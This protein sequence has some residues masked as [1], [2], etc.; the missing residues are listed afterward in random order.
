[1][2]A[3]AKATE[4]QTLE[5]NAGGFA[6]LHD[7]RFPVS[8]VANTLQ[9]YLR[10]IVEKIQPLKVIL[11]GSYAYGTP[12]DHSDFDLLVIRKSLSSSKASNME[13]RVAIQDVSAP[14]ASFTFLSQTPAGLE[15]KMR[16]ESF[17]YREI[18][19]KG[20]ELYAAEE[21]Q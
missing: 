17:I 3:A 18:V 7:S 4:M 10:A 5:N 8:R 15:E 14:P 19:E 9:P 21:N 2:F 6:A 12:T 11:F 1:M 13:I 20:L 16:S